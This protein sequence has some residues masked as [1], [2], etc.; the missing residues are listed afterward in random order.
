MIRGRQVLTFVERKR[1]GRGDWTDTGV[2]RRSEGWSVQP[3]SPEEQERVG[4]QVRRRW[5]VYGPPE[6]VPATWQVETEGVP[7]ADGL[8]LD[9]HGGIEVWPAWGGRPHHAE[10]VLTL[11]EG[12]AR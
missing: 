3:M 11:V 9:V 2:R 10:G 6:H 5:S 12:E 1:V 8:R 4:L 7:G